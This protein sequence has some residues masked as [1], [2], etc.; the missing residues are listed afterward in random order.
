MNTRG[1]RALNG[2]GDLPVYQ[3]QSNSEYRGVVSGSQAA[4]DKF[5]CREGKS[6]DRQLRSQS[7]CLVS[8]D[9]EAH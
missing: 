3:T 7:L 8:K 9:V 1:G 2:L 6:P 5:R 4:G